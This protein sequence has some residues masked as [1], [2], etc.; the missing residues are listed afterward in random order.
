[1][2]EQVLTRKRIKTSFRT[3]YF[4][5]STHFARILHYTVNLLTLRKTAQNIRKKILKNLR[6]IKTTTKRQTRKRTAAILKF[7]FPTQK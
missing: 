7:H 1:M 3:I 5:Q 2:E 6:A 4:V